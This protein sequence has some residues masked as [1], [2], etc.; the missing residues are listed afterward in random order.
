M[1]KEGYTDEQKRDILLQVMKVALRDAT[2]ARGTKYAPDFF[3]DEAIKQAFKIIEK[4]EHQPEVDI[5]KNARLDLYTRHLLTRLFLEY[6]EEYELNEENLELA[7][8]LIEAEAMLGG[9]GTDEDL[10]EM[11]DYTAEELERLRI[12]AKYFGGIDNDAVIA[13]FSKKY[14]L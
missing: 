9:K 11:F 5:W 6:G 3:V 1:S 10:Y 13:E 8:N 2:R 4:Y 12:I 14:G 7:S